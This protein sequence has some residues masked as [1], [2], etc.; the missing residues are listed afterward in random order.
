MS[1]P[2]VVVK[3]YR[4]WYRRYGRRGFWAYGWTFPSDCIIHANET[5]DRTCRAK[6]KY[7]WTYLVQ[8]IDPGDFDYPKDEQASVDVPE[9]GGHRA[10]S[11]MRQGKSEGRHVRRKVAN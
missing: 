1:T 7:R 10:S 2:S 9:R 6:D 3:F 11:R 5:V 4:V 8:E